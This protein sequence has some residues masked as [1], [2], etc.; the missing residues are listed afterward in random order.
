MNFLPLEL[1]VDNRFKTDIKTM[2]LVS[3]TKVEINEEY[4][5]ELRA[6]HMQNNKYAQLAVFSDDAQRRFNQTL[7]ESTSVLNKLEELRERRQER[8]EIFKAI[9]NG[10]ATREEKAIFDQTKD[11]D[12]WVEALGKKDAH[13]EALADRCKEKVQKT[14]EALQTFALEKFSC[15]VI[16]ASRFLDNIELT[17]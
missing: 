4:F 6:E 11:L 15:N 5:K 8:N 13:D 17:M 2:E 7:M 12:Q 16:E 3:T 14:R 10:T 9:R 1:P